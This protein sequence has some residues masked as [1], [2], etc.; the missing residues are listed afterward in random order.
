ME[1]TPDGNISIT[2][3]D[4]DIPELHVSKEYADQLKNYMSN[5]K[6]MSRSEKEAFEYTRQK[7]ESARSFI[8]SIQQRH[9]TLYQTMKAIAHYQKDFILTQDETM[10]RTM[11][12][13]DIAE[14]VGLDLSTISR[15]ETVNMSLSMAVCILW[16]YSSDVRASMQ[17]VKK[18]NIH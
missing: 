17:K 4:G 10:L 15:Y 2:L 14:Q 13:A 8:A 18:W 6:N 9:N 16:I 7:V 3:N 11:R 1:T 5:S 12:L